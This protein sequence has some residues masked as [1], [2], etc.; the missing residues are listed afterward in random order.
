MILKI[1]DILKNNGC[2]IR[3]KYHIYCPGCGG[4]RAAEALFR[5]HPVQSLKYNPVVIL[6]IVVA[7]CITLIHIIESKQNGEKLYNARMAIYI[8]FLIIWFVLSTVRNILLLY[9]GIDVLGDFS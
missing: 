5:L 2:I 1:V 8:S 4:T 9:Y 7:I 3:K 6:L